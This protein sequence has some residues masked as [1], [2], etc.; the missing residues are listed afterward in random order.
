MGLH[1]PDG[2]A[3]NAQS[4]GMFPGFRPRSRSIESAD[5]A[6]SRRAR[7]R[8]IREAIPTPLPVSQ[9][10]ISPVADDCAPRGV[11]YAICGRVHSFN[12]SV[13]IIVRLFEVATRRHLWGYAFEG[14]TR[15]PL[16]LEKRVIEGV[17]SALP[18]W[19]RWAEAIHTDR[20]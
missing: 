13:Q 15:D 11:H 20:K 4:G 19:L 5:W 8:A 3:V 2:W 1:L 9:R 14:E 16:T 7:V 10:R 12:C 17:I 18:I 6:S